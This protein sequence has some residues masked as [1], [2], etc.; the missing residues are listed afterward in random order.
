MPNIRI[1]DIP[2]TASATSSTDFIGI[3][4]S[5]NG[6][7]KLNAYSPTFGGNLTASGTGSHVFGTTN[8]VTLAAGTVTA[9]GIG[10][11]AGI[12][13][14]GAST[15]ATGVGVEVLWDNTSA[16]IQGFNRTGSV[17]TPILVGGSTVGLQ[18]GGVTKFGLDASGNAT[19]SGNLTVNGTGTSSVA[20]KLQLGATTATG[21]NTLL[22]SSG[23]TTGRGVYQIT[24]NGAWLIAGIEGSAGGTSLTGSTAYASFLGSFTATPLHLVSNGTI[25]ATL[26]SGGN[27]L[28]GTTTDGGQK[29]QVSGTANIGNPFST[30]TDDSLILHGKAVYDGSG[31]YG[32]YGSIVLSSSSSFTASARRYLI[33]NAYLA[34][35]FAIIR[36]T[37]ATT[38][39]TIG[40]NGVVSSGTVDFRISESGNATFAGSIA[41]GNTVNTVSPTSPNRTI[42]MVIGGTTYYIHAKTTND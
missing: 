20:G 27:V 4:G 30:S 33:T 13:V 39:P 40:T 1:K 23:I 41:I 31:N 12:Q 18:I 10:K 21:Y 14:T 35:D 38:T 26:T 5:A 17:F 15:A 7:R 32:D 29:L 9:T 25:G 8:T 6:T 37:N 42:T 16:I 28:I 19:L 36:S 3:D 11:I 34:T 24:S 2:T 22:E